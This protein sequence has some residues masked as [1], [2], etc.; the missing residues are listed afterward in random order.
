M[1]VGKVDA[2]VFDKTTCEHFTAYDDDIK[3]VQEIKYPDED[4]AIA[5][6]K[7]DTDLLN[8]FNKALMEIMLSG[9]HDEL[10]KKYLSAN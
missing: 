1:K 2:A 3:I 8:T 6:R 4:Y 10:I 5:F 9:Y 7:E